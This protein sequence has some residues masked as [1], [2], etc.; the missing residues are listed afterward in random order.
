MWF[1]ITPSSCMFSFIWTTHR[2]T[3]GSN[4]DS[5]SKR[6]HHHT[7]SNMF[8]NGISK[9]HC[10][11]ILSCSSQG[12]N[13]WLTIRPIFLSF[14][15]AS[16]VFSTT[17]QI[18]LELPNP[19][20][21][22]IPKCM[23][24]HPINP[25]NIHLLCCVHGNECTW[26]HDAIY[27]MFFCHYMGCW[28]PRGAKTTTCVSFKHVQFFMLMNWHCAHQKWHSHLNQHCDCQP[29]TSRFISQIL[30]HPRI[31]YFPVTQAKEWSYCDWHL[32]NQ[33]L[34]LVVEVF[35]CLHK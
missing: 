22:S 16:L 29:K 14:Q 2:A 24:T 28:F 20:I 13:V 1:L 18:W 17:L 8:S 4:P 25:M 15:L 27:N 23:C 11:Q 31:C 9:A 35:E 34:L 6:L 10:A 12:V 33:F 7:F 3:N 30:H 19:S 5:I 26:I 21:A 32:V